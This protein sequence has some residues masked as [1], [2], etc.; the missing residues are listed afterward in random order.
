MGF[1]TDPEQ[2]LVEFTVKRT[3]I[4]LFWPQKASEK[5]YYSALNGIMAEYSHMDHKSSL[6]DIIKMIK[7]SFPDTNFVVIISL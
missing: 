6:E 5:L 2:V 1:W 7:F 4:L 3:D